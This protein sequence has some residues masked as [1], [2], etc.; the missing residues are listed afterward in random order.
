MF[1][2]VPLQVRLVA[3]VL[4]LVAVALTAMGV[5]TVMA[6]RGYLLDRIDAQIDNVGAQVATQLANGRTNIVVN[7]PEPS[8]GGLRLPNPY[9]IEARDANGDL[10]ASVPRSVP[11]SQRPQLNKA[12]LARSNIFVVEGAGS[13]WRVLVVPGWEDQRIVIAATMADVDSAVRRLMWLDFLIGLGL[14]VLIGVVGF[15]VVR[16]SLR[17][18]VEIEQTAGAIAGGDLSRRVPER[19]PGTEVGRLGRA[20]NGMLSQIEAAF[21]ARAAS[22]HRARV[23]E[24]RMRRF[25]AD[26]SHELRT[27][28]TTIRGFAELYRQGAGEHRSPAGEPERLVKRIEDE[29]ARMGLLVED[30]LLL[31]RLDQQRPLAMEP[32]E[33]AVLTADAVEAARAQA[34][35]RDIT[36]SVTPAVIIGDESRLRQVI[37]NLVGNALAHTPPGT[38]VSISLSTNDEWASVEVSDRGPGLTP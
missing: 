25:V 26:A 7:L 27:P 22:E 28:L 11:S 24:E 37:G 16:H 32:V 36:F 14:L 3:T 13:R 10:T 31:A 17:P 21:D 35:D 19:D 8:A 1:Q 5:A 6:L 9:V 38:P 12:D 30:L 34:P 33:L 2:R 18:L 20:L 15:A 23:S 29:A 4:A